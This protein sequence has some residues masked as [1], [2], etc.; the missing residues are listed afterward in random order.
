MG[1]DSLSLRL[2]REVK[3]HLVQ[4]LPFIE[5]R[6]DARKEKCPVFKE[7]LSVTFCGKNANPLCIWENAGHGKGI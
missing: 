5:E 6:A 3:T 2:G 7:K 1:P 4:L